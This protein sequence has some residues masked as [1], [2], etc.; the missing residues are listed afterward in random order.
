MYSF[1][2][3]ELVHLFWSSFSCCFLACTRVSQ[4]AGK[5]VWYSHFFKNF[6][7]FVVSHRVRD[8]SVVNVEDVDALWNFLAFP[9]IQQILAIYYLVPLPFLYLAC[10]S[11][12]SQ[13][14][15]SWRIL[16]ITL[17]ACEMSAI[18]RQFEHIS[19][20]PFFGIGM[21]TDLFQSCDQCWVFLIF[22]Y[23]E[24]CTLTAISFRIWN[25]H[26]DIC[27]QEIQ[28]RG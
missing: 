19:T 5:V 23:I 17:L 1:P 15:Y 27:N 8:F 12:N 2:N 6:P 10:M 11:G 22:W 18:V 28:G 24:C 4:E 21:K 25:Q 13:F 14:M 9:S 3:F 7:Q 20:L 16:S 26:T